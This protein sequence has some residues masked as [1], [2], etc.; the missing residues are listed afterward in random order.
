M[1]LAKAV[2]AR[3]GTGNQ[4]GAL[5][6]RMMDKEIRQYQLLVD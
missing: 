3:R 1:E 6:I 4:Q 2:A 5:A